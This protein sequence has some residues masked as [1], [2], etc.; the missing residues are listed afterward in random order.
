M[1][2]LTG[3]DGDIA[4]TGTGHT[5]S[6]IRLWTATV[7]YTVSEVTSFADAQ[8]R[9]FRR[10][11]PIMEGTISGV[12]DDAA[13][14]DPGVGSAGGPAAGD[15]VAGA[16]VTF[17]FDGSAPV[18]TWANTVVMSNIGAALDKNGDAVITF[19]FASGDV[20]D[21]AEVWAV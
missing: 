18:R 5:G 19:D 15:G 14:S 6:A 9:R 20:N 12:P 3:N 17:T 2:A 10:G 11:L 8:N 16:V 7:S 13:S 21:L 4:F 1:A